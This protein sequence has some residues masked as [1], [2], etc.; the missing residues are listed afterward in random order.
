[1]RRP[2]TIEAVVGS[3]DALGLAAKLGNSIDRSNTLHK[4]YA[5]VSL[6][7]VRNVDD[8]RRRSRQ[9]NARREQIWG[10]KYH[11]KD[12]AMI[13]W[14]KSLATPAGLEP[15]TNSLEGCCSN[16]LSYGANAANASA[17]LHITPA[18]RYA[19]R[20]R[21]VRPASLRY[22]PSSR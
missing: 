1:M 3:V 6:E 19:I 9:K 2:G 17:A 10:K 18:G 8:S 21:K 5:P 20:V 4:T 11:P 7:A 22:F 15:A 13:K 14:L 12:R 16:P